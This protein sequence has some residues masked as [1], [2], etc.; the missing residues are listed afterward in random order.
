MVNYWC[1][2]GVGCS[3]ETGKYEAQ[4]D[5]LEK[6]DRMRVPRLT[7]ASVMKRQMGERKGRRGDGVEKEGG[8][9]ERQ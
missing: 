8:E 4:C 7:E 5:S 2:F 3:S 9:R 1:F 6:G